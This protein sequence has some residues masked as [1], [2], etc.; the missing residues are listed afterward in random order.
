MRLRFMLQPTMSA[1]LA[2]RDG[3]KDARSGRAAYFMTVLR[4]PQKRIGLLNEG[5]NAT[6]RI[7]MMAS[8]WT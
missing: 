6:A 3:L 7:I 5:L 8:R 2:V 1:I 4:N